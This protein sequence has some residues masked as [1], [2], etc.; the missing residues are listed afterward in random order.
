MS[1]AEGPTNS[2]TRHLRRG[3]DR[4]EALQRLGT[5]GQWNRRLRSL[6]GRGTAFPDRTLPYL[7]ALWLP[8]YLVS[9]PLAPRAKPS[10]EGADERTM[11]TLHCRVCALSGD[12][13]RLDESA[14]CFSEPAPEGD[15]ES[16]R[17]GWR[18]DFVLTAE[19]ARRSGRA[20]LGS[21]LLLSREA[22]RH[23]IGE[24]VQVSSLRHPYWLFVW[25]RRYGRLDLRLLDGLDG[26]KAGSGVRAAILKALL[27]S[28]D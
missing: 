5:V 12:A 25:E 11:P 1:S 16:K 2:A 26:S 17:Q 13:I 9:A 19:Q 23:A 20:L 24:P 14:L 8:G 21:L 7:E 3:I 10:G 27:A 4:T 6:T 18:P 22:G 28:A 15:S